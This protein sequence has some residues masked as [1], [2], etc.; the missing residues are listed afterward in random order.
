LSWQTGF[1]WA[2]EYAFIRIRKTQLDELAQQGSARAR[3][4]A[5]I[6]GKLDQYISAS[7]LGVT[8]CSLASGGS[9]SPRVARLLGPSVT[10]LPDPLL[11]VLSFA[12]RSA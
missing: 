9:A 4:S 1:S 5:S 12:W 7:Q 8:L 10:W 2:A 6:V 3:L 11:E